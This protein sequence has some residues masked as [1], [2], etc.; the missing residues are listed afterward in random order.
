MQSQS[1]PIPIDSLS[2]RLNKLQHD[3]DFMYCDYELHKLIMD[4][5]DLAHSI[6]ISSNGVIINV[7]NS[8]Y[9]RKLYNAYLSNY[10]SDCAL[11]DSLKEKIEAVKTAVFVRMMTSVFTDKEQSVLTKSFDVVNK[12]VM[13]VDSSL[14]Y[15]DIVI[16]AYRDKM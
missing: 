8:R 16:K 3:Y 14:D 1:A 5:K 6:D 11:F 12:A 4:L 15:Y 10:N 2:L 9:D 13:K 7:Y